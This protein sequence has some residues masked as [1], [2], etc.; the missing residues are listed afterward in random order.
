MIDLAQAYAV[1][2]NLGK[3]VDINPIINIT[4]HRQ[5]FSQAEGK[6]DQSQVIDPGIAFILNDILADNSAR[7]PAF[8]AN[9]LLNI[10]GKNV[11]VK[12]GTTNDYR[13]A[14]TIG[15]TPSIVT[16]VW[17]GNNDNAPMKRGAAG[18]VVAA[19]IWH[20]FMKKV[21]GDTPIEYFKEPEIPETG[22]AILD[23]KIDAGET[24]KIDTASGLLATEN[25]PANYT[26]EIIYKQD[27]CILYYIDKDDPLGKAPKDPSKDP[28]FELWEDRVIKWAEKQGATTSTEIIIPTEY[29]SLHALEN[30]PIFKILFPLNNQTITESFITASLEAS[31]PRGINRA[32][33]YI[34]NNLITINSSYPFNLE[35]QINFLNNGF[36]NLKVRV[37]DDID[38]CSEQSVEF[39]LISDKEPNNSEIDISWLEP[40]NGL[41]VNG[42]DFPLNIKLQASN[43]MQIAKVNIYLVTEDKE[44]LMATLQPIEDEMVVGEWEKSPPPGTYGLIAEANGWGGQIKKSQKITITITNE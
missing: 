24:I 4:N 23:G 44:S 26:K 8:G 2:A 30:R 35:K 32:E 42:I 33:Y 11:A 20:D 19:P 38:N 29:D 13:D 31:A 40:N 10:P 16:G 7:T 43:Y 12:T 3:K 25:T 15:Y 28:Q 18:G 17:V 36:H 5:S 34:N 1:F 22:K 39:N 9:S 37:C 21:L 14:W 27:H 6:N 41:A